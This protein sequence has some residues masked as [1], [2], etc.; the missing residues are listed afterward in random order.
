MDDK[1]IDSLIQSD[2][3]ISQTITEANKS[4]E[5]SIDDILSSVMSISTGNAQ[6]I[7][8]EVINQA[9]KEA[10]NIKASLTGTLTTN[11]PSTSEI[12]S[13]EALKS[14]GNV[15]EETMGNLTSVMSNLEDVLNQMN[16]SKS[17]VVTTG[18]EELP[19]ASPETELVAQGTTQQIDID[20]LSTLINDFKSISTMDWASKWLS[21]VQK[22]VD[23]VG[24]IKE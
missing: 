10:Q 23:E 6:K 21:Y 16:A 1:L 8:K 15:S 4:A 17:T 9:T 7:E 24:I 5:E 3:I 20:K 12:A 22:I 11:P 19:K 2:E 13:I 18:G 14:E